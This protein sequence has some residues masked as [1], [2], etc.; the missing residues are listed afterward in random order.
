MPPKIRSCQQTRI[1]SQFDPRPEV[2]R[3]HDP[4]AS[5]KLR[6]SLS[7]MNKP[8]A[9]LHILAPDVEKINHDHTYCLKFSDTADI[10]SVSVLVTPSS[11]HDK[12]TAR[13]L[14][15]EEITARKELFHVSTALR[16]KIEE[17]TRKQSNTDEWYDVRAQ[18]I[19]S[20]IC[21]QILNQKT[22]PSV[23]VP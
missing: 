6:C 13:I 15:P 19:T 11:N 5:E 10:P 2:F 18:R 21:G 3:K 23:S 7:L 4:K 22:K 17:R 8:C 14:S 1:A 12:Y 20:S 9:F 16:H